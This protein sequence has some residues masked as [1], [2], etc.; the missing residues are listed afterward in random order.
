MID[1]DP[2]EHEPAPLRK[3]VRIHADSDPVVG[4]PSGS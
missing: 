3:R 4:H 1:L 2:A